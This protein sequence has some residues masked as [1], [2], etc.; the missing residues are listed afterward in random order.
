MGNVIEGT[1]KYAHPDKK[2][3]LVEADG[4]TTLLAKDMTDNG[5]PDGQQ[6]AAGLAT[7]YDSYHTMGDVAEGTVTKVTASRS[8]WGDRPVILVTKV[9]EPMLM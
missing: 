5:H 3:W 1:V 2:V 6:I 7:L 8:S 4:K 9:L